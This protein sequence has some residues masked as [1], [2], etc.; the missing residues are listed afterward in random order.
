MPPPRK[1]QP[2]ARWAAKL[3]HE[4]TPR[5]LEIL[6]LPLDGQP[7]RPC[8]CRRVGSRTCHHPQSCA[9]EHLA[10][11]PVDFKSPPPN[12]PADGGPSVDPDGAK[13]LSR[14]TVKESR[15]RPGNLIFGTPGHSRARKPP[16]LPVW[17]IS[18]RCSLMWGSAVFPHVLSVPTSARRGVCAIPSQ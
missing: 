1:T 15:H 2:T 3:W 12:R 18:L 8:A 9:R 11:F 10:G 7:D 14:F 13:A 4:P 6:R 16:P 5:W 17:V